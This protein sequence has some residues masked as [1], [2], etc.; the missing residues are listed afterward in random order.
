MT[1][2]DHPLVKRSPR[3]DH[4]PIEANHR[5]IACVAVGAQAGGTAVLV[6]RT[7]AL[8]NNL[9][10]VGGLQHG[11]VAH[12]TSWPA[13]PTPAAH[14]DDGVITGTGPMGDWGRARA[15]GYSPVRPGSKSG[16]MGTGDVRRRQAPGNRR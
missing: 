1:P 6:E 10:C 4:A 12:R 15:D 2:S 8:T 5:G 3:A 9:S 14:R 13:N 7:Y 16:M 11:G